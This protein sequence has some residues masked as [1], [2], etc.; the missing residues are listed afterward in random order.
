MCSRVRELKRLGRP[1]RPLQSNIIIL[2]LVQ[3][4]RRHPRFRCTRINAG[5]RTGSR[6]N[7]I[8]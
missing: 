7:T 2:I 1:R 8:I 6:E 3:A 5:K 4:R